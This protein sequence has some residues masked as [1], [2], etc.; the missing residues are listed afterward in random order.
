MFFLNSY[1][2]VFKK[3]KFQPYCSFWFVLFFVYLLCNNILQYTKCIRL[4]CEHHFVNFSDK[5]Y[6]GF[7]ICSHIKAYSIYIE[8]KNK[9]KHKTL[10][11]REVN[12]RSAVTFGLVKRKKENKTKH[13]H[14]HLHAIFALD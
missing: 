8:K 4:F 3:R 11:K 14:I 10:N 2:N 13:T 1:E 6:R 9:T 12:L 7:E 5:K